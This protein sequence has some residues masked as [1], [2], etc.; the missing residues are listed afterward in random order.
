[1][2]WLSTAIVRW[3]RLRPSGKIRR[4]DFGEEFKRIDFAFEYQMTVG[5]IIV[6]RCQDERMPDA[7]E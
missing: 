3:P 5:P 1:M 2:A 7:L 6:A 4:P